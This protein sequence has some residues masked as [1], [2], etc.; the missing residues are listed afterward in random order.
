MDFI[1]NTI[2]MNFIQ[3]L[4][5]IEELR[6]SLTNQLI[7][8]SEAFYIL[9]FKYVFQE[10]SEDDRGNLLRL[11]LLP[12]TIGVKT[13]NAIFKYIDKLKHK[14]QYMSSLERFFDNY[15]TFNEFYMASVRQFITR[16]QVKVIVNK[17]LYNHEFQF[18]DENL[19]LD[20]SLL[21]KNGINA[22]PNFD[23]FYN[24]NKVIYKYIKH[25]DVYN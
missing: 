15:K 10:N 4:K 2:E 7:K 1:M 17:N 12:Q 8:L 14:A 9:P 25:D 20:F 18:N 3:N 16:M 6:C 24:K 22:L 11:V 21:K 5:D 23:T 13:D 19:G